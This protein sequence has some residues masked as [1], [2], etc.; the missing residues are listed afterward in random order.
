MTISYTLPPAAP[1][2]TSAASTT[3]TTGVAGTFTVTTT[4]QPTPALTQTRALPGGVTFT[5]NGDGTATLAGTP[6]ALTGGIY[7]LTVTAANGVT[8]AATQAFTLTV[9]EPPAI[10]SAAS[11]TFITGVAGTFTVTTTGQPTPALTQTRALPGGVTFTDNGDG[12]ATLAGTPAA[13]TGGTYAITITAANGVNPH[14]TQHFTLTVGEPPAITSAAAA[15]FTTGKAGTFTVTTTGVPTPALTESGALPGGVTFTDNGDGTATLAGTPAAL[16]GGIY[17]LTVTA[18]NGVT[19]A[20]TQ[21]FTLTVGEPPAITSA[22]STT[23]ITGV[24][25]TFT[26]TTTGQPTPALTQ[27]RALPGGVTFTD[28]GDGTA[29][30]AGTPAALTGGTYAITI[31]A[32]NGVN[33]HATQHF[34]LT[35]GEPPAITSAAAATFTT[36]KAGTFTV[37][38]TGVPTPALTESGALPGGVTFT[39][40]GNG[41][42]TLAGTPA[43]LTGGI[44]PLTVTAANG[45][46]PAA[47]QAFTLTVVTPLAVTGPSLPNGTV[48]VPYRATLTAS[49]GSPPYTWSLAGGSSLPTGLGL[50]AGGIISGTPTKA[51]T[52]SFTVEVNDPVTKTFLLTIQPAATTSTPTATPAA[53]LAPVATTALTPTASTTLAGTGADPLSMVALACGLLVLGATLV[54]AA[55]GRR[56]PAPERR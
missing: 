13:L 28:N 14:A 34:T 25:G 19:P 46:T 44:Y 36:G 32:A 2:I 55:R 42:A 20:A 7:P 51:G 4:G 29:T 33:P 15:T 12:T 17:P 11:T 31:T 10:T 1:A 38:T 37:T 22:A 18:A 26:V 41:K 56:R 16:T 45:V 5:D 9:G 3:F 50:S 8:P 43:A 48:D 35:V 27:T 39:D 52:T 47:T 40:N 21:A 24:A 49:G 53:T 30:L 23:F 54:A 6:A